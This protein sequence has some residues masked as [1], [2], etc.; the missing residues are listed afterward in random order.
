ME[1]SLAYEGKIN[2]LRRKI[3]ILMQRKRRIDLNIL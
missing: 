2:Y 3:L 1:G